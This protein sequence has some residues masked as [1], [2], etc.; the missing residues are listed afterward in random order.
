MATTTITKISVS[1]TA[2]YNLTDSADFT[3][4][5]SGAGN[6]VVFPFDLKDLIV[7]KNDT[8]LS[9]TYTFLVGQIPTEYTTFSAS[10][11]DPTLAVADGK[12]VLIQPSSLFS[13]TSGNMTIECDGTSKI[14]VLDL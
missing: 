9:R 8:G 5:T 10:V 13:N 7:L 14:L 1:Q 2:G 12:T 11:T 6:G 3:T 4:M